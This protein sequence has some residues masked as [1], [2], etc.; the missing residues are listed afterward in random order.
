MKLGR[1]LAQVSGGALALLVE[2]AIHYEIHPINAVNTATGALIVAFSFWPGMLVGYLS[3]WIQRHIAKDEEPDTP[4]A[5]ALCAAMWFVYLFRALTLAVGL[6]A[7]SNW[8]Q[9]PVNWMV[10]FFEL[11]V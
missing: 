8:T 5:A 4:A 3:I 2:G 6:P 11:W 10:R 7:L 9:A 1:F